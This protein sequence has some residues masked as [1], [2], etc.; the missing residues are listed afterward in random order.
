[1][2]TYTTFYG[3]L[4]GIWFDNLKI[5]LTLHLHIELKFLNCII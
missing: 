4:Y 5:V 1:M 3:Y 2:Y